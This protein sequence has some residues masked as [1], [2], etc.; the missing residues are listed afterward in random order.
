MQLLTD[1]LPPSLLQ[2]LANQFRQ[3]ISKA[4]VRYPE[5]RGDEDSVTGGLIQAIGDIAKGTDQVTGFSWSTSTWKLRGRGQGA[6]EKEIGADA[7][8][9]IQVKDQAGN[10]VTRKSLPIQC[11]KE[12]VERDRLLL[13]QASQLCSIPG[14]GIVVDYTQTGYF[15]TSAQATVAAEGDRRRVPPAAV[16]SLG[17]VLADQFLPCKIGSTNIYFDAINETLL[18]IGDGGLSALPFSARNRIR[19]DIKPSQRTRALR[20]RPGQ[21]S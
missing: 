4:V 12:W 6:P 3:G 14:G 19:V 16:N 2:E 10:L 21:L 9:E 11:K 8:L 7:I 15:A 20:R 5:L 18:I 1:V 13:S 17:D